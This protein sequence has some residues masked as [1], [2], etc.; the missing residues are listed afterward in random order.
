MEPPTDFSNLTDIQV[1]HFIW[2]DTGCISKRLQDIQIST[3]VSLVCR[4]SQVKIENTYSGVRIFK[5]KAEREL[6][7]RLG[8]NWKKKVD[9]AHALLALKTPRE[10]PTPSSSSSSS[11]AP[12]EENPYPC[13]TEDFIM[14][15]G[16]PAD[17]NHPGYKKG[18]GLKK[19]FLANKRSQY[20]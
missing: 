17:P 20:I 9:A 8:P 7:T 15:D 12:A 18:S 10:R 11:S 4:L 19:I 3:L 5:E 2:G 14:F 16:L 6:A 1:F 13:P